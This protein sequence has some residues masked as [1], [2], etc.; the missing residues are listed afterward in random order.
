MTVTTQRRLAYSYIGMSAK[1]RTLVLTVPKE[2]EIPPMY[3]KSE[4]ERIALALTLGAEAITHIERK[5]IDVSNDEVRDESVR[6]ATQEFERQSQVTAAKLKRAEEATRAANMRIE[7]MEADSASLRS[8]IQREVA[9][10]FEMIL[11]T[12]DEQVAQAHAAL[13]KAMESVGKKVE[14][15]QTSITK[16]YASSKDKG[17]MGEMLMENHLKKAYDCD[18]LV[19][20]KER[21][22]ADIRMRREGGNYFWEVKN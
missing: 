18:V 19:V 9:K 10:T 20:S 5:A 21:E 1:T 4:A 15:L 14:S 7:A 11:K 16:T 3:F 6:A 13:E 8:Q 22:S 12:K 17:N 2:Y